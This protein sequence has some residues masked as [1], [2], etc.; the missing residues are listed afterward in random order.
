MTGENFSPIELANMDLIHWSA[1]SSSRRGVDE[2]KGVDGDYRFFCQ[3]KD[4]FYY[5]RRIYI[6]ISKL[7]YIDF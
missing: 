6:A 7:L 2:V 3:L 1:Q 4:P 5:N